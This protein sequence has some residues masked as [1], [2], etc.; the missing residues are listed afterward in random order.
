MNDIVQSLGIFALT[1]ILCGANRCPLFC[2]RTSS[3]TRAC[4]RNACFDGENWANTSGT[5]SAN[6]IDECTLPKILFSAASSEN[7][8]GQFETK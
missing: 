8:H 2:I 6:R 1:R 3:L 5:D 4:A 7:N